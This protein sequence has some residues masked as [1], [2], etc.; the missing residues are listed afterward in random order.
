MNW[1]RDGFS[2]TRSVMAGIPFRLQIMVLCGALALPAAAL[3]QTPG[4][5]V[6]LTATQLFGVA[7]AAR[8]AGDYDTAET[9]YRALAGNPDIEVRN[10]AR[11]RLALMLADTLRKPREAAV[12]LRKILDE[13]PETPRVRLELARILAGMGNLAAAERQFRAA[14]A[15]GLP[16]E[17]EKYVRFYANALSASKPFGGSLEVAL[18]PD[19][20]VN[21][22]TRSDTL[23]TVI[24]DFT[25]SDDAR[26]T[27][28]LGLA[29][30]GQAY[31]RTGIDKRARLLARVSGRG[32]FYGQ[33]QFNDTVISLQAGPEYALGKDRLNVAG[34]VAWRWF[35]TQPYSMTYGVSG[36]WQHPVGKRGQMRIDAA[37]NAVENRRNALQSATDFNLAVTLDRAF[38]ARTGGGVQ[39]SAGRTQARDP[40]FSDVTGG[41][42]AYLFHEWGKTTLVG[43]I[44]YTRLEADARLLL[45][46]KRRVDDRFSANLGATLR[47]LRVGTFAPFV[48]VTAEH[49]RS[50]VGIYSYTRIA[51]EAGI[52]SAF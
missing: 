43:G 19:S 2:G 42:N 44:G 31:F 16:P 6:E 23:S 22:A 4:R 38:T 8:D 39:L 52:G 17:V 51:G 33:S 15:S 41:I 14:E 28:G 1:T 18:A 20:N 26:S 49:N 48:R 12:E 40:G 35:G 29:V 11:F 36:N 10:E 50:S 34:G 30:K 37:I 27:S 21:R 45:Y 24:G 25:L 3:A 13:K 47:S 32:Y 5:T 9:A 7:D 46:P